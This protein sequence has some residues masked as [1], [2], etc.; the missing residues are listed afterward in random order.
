M[1]TI[2][3]SLFITFSSLSYS[4]GF[5]WPNV[6]YDHARLFLFNIDSDK[7]NRPDFHIYSDSIYAT[8]KLGTGEKLSEKFLGKIHS[9]IAR[10]GEA[11]QMG[12]S[13]CYIPRHGI[14]YY[15]AKGR[16]LAS[17]SICFECGKISMW[18]EKK[19]PDINHQS[20]HDWD[21]V[22]QQFESLQKEFKNY[23]IA[24]YEKE[25][26]Y[27]N[28]CM[29]NEEYTTAGEVFIKTDKLDSLYFKHY[30]IDEVKSWV[31]GKR[32]T[33]RLDEITKI[34]AG[35]DEWT[36]KELSSKEKNSL[37]RFSFDE[38]DPF[39][40][41]AIIKDNEIILPNGVSVGMS[42]EDVM[43]TFPVYDGPAYPERIQLKDEKLELN[44]YFKNRTLVKITAGFSIV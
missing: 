41:E 19:I 35:G 40:V 15:N 9:K 44:Y 21:K 22:E 32:L 36:Y 5:R 11:M 6:P 13:K 43:A 14:I 30:G 24:V 26:A 3:L 12:L 4:G 34:T 28:Y 2:F 8:S 37:F 10:Y 1:K 27:Q 38:E 16:P 18:S 33:L 7:Q 25:E 31:K 17:L 42:V 29:E 39:L 20:N 23:G